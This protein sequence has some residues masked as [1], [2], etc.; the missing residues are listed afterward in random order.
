MPKRILIAEDDTHIREL[1]TMQA[2]MRGYEVTAVVDGLEYL[3]AVS[4][5]DFDLIITDIMMPDLNGA[6]ATEIMKLQGCTV[7][8]IALTAL[9]VEAIRLIES[10]FEK[11]LHKPL[12]LRELF[13]CVEVLLSK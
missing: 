11:V 4:K 7:P 10:K 12:D 1:L 6:S 13:E 3:V 5:T 2:E 8:V 9:D